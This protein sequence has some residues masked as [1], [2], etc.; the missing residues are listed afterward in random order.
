MGMMGIAHMVN[1][2]E[3]AD[4]ELMRVAYDTIAPAFAIRHAAMP[5]NVISA[6]I[7]LLDRI[8][9]SGTILDV[10][11][12]T[13]RD[14]AWFESHG[15]QVIGFDLSAGMLREARTRTRGPLVQGDMR[16]LPFQNA[17][18]A[19]VWSNAALLHLPKSDAPASLREMRRVLLPGGYL[20]LGVQE[21][22]GEV[23][24]DDSYGAGVQRFFAR[25][26]PEEVAFLL[27]QAGFSMDDIEHNASGARRWLLS[28]ARATAQSQ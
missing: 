22:Q 27:T 20:V 2:H 25:Y 4:D 6:G 18:F 10:G 11:C 8:G 3:P 26:D 9:P 14:M 12:G 13:G 5:P 23:W 1:L 21:G 19:A 7:R 28:M 24:E 17:C 16:L 15:G